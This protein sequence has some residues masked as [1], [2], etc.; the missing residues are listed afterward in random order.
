MEESSLDDLAADRQLRQLSDWI[1]TDTEL[2]NYR[3]TRDSHRS[4]PYGSLP[5]KVPKEEKQAQNSA[6]QKIASLAMERNQ[7]DLFDRAFFALSKD[8]RSDVFF[9]LGEC[10]ALNGEDWES[11]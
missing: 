1:L 2:S 10:L 9:P 3:P 8:Q 11:E 4:M 6:R 5:I 7:I